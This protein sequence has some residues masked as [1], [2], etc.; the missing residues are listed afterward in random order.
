M[1][2]IRHLDPTK[3]DN[4]LRFLRDGAGYATVRVG[5]EIRI[6]G[7]LVDEPF[8]KALRIVRSGKPQ[9]VELAELQFL[10]SKRPFHNP[11]D[12][13]DLNNNFASKF[14][15]DSDLGFRL[16]KLQLPFFHAHPS[17]IPDVTSII[18]PHLD[19][20]GEIADVWFIYKSEL[21]D[22][23]LAVMRI[24]HAAK[25]MPDIMGIPVNKFGGFQTLEKLQPTSS[26]GISKEIDFCLSLFTPTILGTAFD[27]IGGTYIF[28]LK[29]P[30]EY[31]VPFPPRLQDILGSNIF[32]EN[33]KLSEKETFKK[34]TFSP[35]NVGDLLRHF[36][37]RLAILHKELLDPT[38]F[39]DT[40]GVLDPRRWHLTYTTTSR[41]FIDGTMAQTEYLNQYLRK[42]MA[43]RNLDSLAQLLYDSP[44]TK[45]KEPDIFKHLCKKDVILNSFGPELAKFPAPFGNL[46]R[47]WNHTAVDELYNKLLDGVFVPGRRLPGKVRVAAKDIPENDYITSFLR[48]VRNTQHGYHVRNFPVL[49]IHT[50]SVPDCLGDMVKFPVLAYIQRPELILKATILP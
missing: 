24:L 17:Q 29:K 33:K 43:F 3:L 45:L 35:D 32:S 46:L 36:V 25:D 10:L 40:T 15:R 12:L 34:W 13:I 5:D 21:V 48:E 37:D 28:V 22:S 39:A 7:S 1:V 2:I 44:T 23:R 20:F 4:A 9:K 18:A 26:L 8:Y 19:E 49:Q 11:L 42:I 16:N 6:S 50:G 41:L 38:N 30:R 31:T 27:Q 47:N 14:P